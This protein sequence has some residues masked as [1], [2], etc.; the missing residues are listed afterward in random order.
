MPC[1]PSPPSTFC[2]EKVTTSSLAKSRRCANAA[3]VASQIVSPCRVGRNEIAVGHAH[4]R[5]RAVPG[6]D[7]VAVEIDRREIGQPAVVGLDDARI[8]ELELLHH[9]GDPA[10]AE[11]FPGDHVDAARAEQRPQRHLDGAGVGGR[12]DADPVVGRHLE[13]FAGERRSPVRAW[14]CRA[15]RGASGRA[16]TVSSACERPA[17]ALG[18]RA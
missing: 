14:P 5:G 9:I 18:A 6:E 11:T 2:Q 4:A 1:A 17:G 7:H 10:G 16:R 13:D 12:H 15:W 8:G 3:E